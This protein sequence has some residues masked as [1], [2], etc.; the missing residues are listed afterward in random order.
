[1]RMNAL[2]TVHAMA[3]ELSAPLTHPALPTHSQ[4]AVPATNGAP[5]AAAP[6][7]AASPASSAAEVPGGMRALGRTRRWGTSSLRTRPTATASLLGAIAPRFFYPLMARYDD[8]ASSFRL[9]TEDCFLLEA[10][11]QVTCICHTCICMRIHEG[12][13]LLEALLSAARRGQLP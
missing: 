3:E 4:R 5:P 9:L 12:C 2:R 10:L 7:T 1:M 6:P 11:L 8:P 13:F